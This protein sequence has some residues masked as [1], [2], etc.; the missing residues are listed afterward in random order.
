MSSSER[1][2]RDVKAKDSEVDRNY[3]VAA[4]CRFGLGCRR[5]LG[6]WLATEAIDTVEAGCSGPT[7]C[8]RA[9]SR[10]LV[11][12]RLGSFIP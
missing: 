6:T 11:P 1:R 4:A 10:N 2:R 12:G 8:Y 7:G 9:R 5:L 3:V